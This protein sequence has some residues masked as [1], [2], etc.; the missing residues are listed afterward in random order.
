MRN[1]YQDLQ[2]FKQIKVKEEE[3]GAEETAKLISNEFGTVWGKRLGDMYTL[4][5]RLQAEDSSSKLMFNSVK[6][7]TKLF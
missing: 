3:L 2:L 7:A 4:L 6:N 1:V 5:V